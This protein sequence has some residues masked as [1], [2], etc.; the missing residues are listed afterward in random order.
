M[1]EPVLFKISTQLDESTDVSSCTQLIALVR[2]VNDGVV[3]ED[4]LFCK[5]L[6]KNTTAKDVMQLVKDFFAKHDLDIG[7][8]F[9]GH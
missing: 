9:C 4:F 2:Y 5:D 6:P 8:W 1:S 3:K 7:H